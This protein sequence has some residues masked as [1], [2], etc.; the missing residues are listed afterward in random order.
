LPTIHIG[1]STPATENIHFIKKRGDLAKIIGQ[2][3]LGP[4]LHIR[5]GNE[6]YAPKSSGCPQRPGPNNTI[7]SKNAHKIKHK[8]ELCNYQR[9]SPLQSYNG[10]TRAFLKVQD[11]C[12]GLCTYC[13]IPKT[14]PIVHSR[15]VN[16]ILEEAQALVRY[17]HKEIVITGIN[18]GA[19]GQKSVRRRNWQNHRN[20][21]LADLLDKIAR[22]TG[23]DR[24]RLSS[25]EPADV[26]TYLLDIFCKHRNIM[27]HLHLSLQSGSDAVLKRMCR[28]YRAE[29]IREKVDMIKSK[30]DRPAI[31]TDIIVGFPGETNE[32]F[33]KTV[34]LAEYIGFAK[35]HVFKFSPRNGTAAARL[36]DR[37]DNQVINKRSKILR[38]FDVELGRKF[39]EKFIG[40]SADVL[41]ESYNGKPSGR[42]ERYFMV[43]VVQ[44]V[45][46]DLKFQINNNDLVK[47]KLI[48]NSNN[49]MAGQVEGR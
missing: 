32:D 42:C 13:I 46:S 30:L 26:T 21:K 10:Q 14:R 36:P 6:G 4:H 15:P 19:Y 3:A 2:I 49:S 8:K 20:N 18:L 12:D 7:K 5:E 28:Q 47:V 41:I 22:I 31:T 37:I 38:E 9:L 23:L 45:N 27:P 44:K 24:I 43:N 17:G 1:R 16:E 40:E 33:E 11:G 34:N 35:M 48:R 25:I 39:R 29:Q